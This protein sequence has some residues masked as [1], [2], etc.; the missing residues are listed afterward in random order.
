MVTKEA[1]PKIVGFLYQME[2]ALYRIFSN[3]HNSAVFGIETADD[4]VEE[5][6]F[7]NGHWHVAFEQDK[8]ASDTQPQPYQDSSKNL[9]HTVHIWLDAMKE[10]REKYNKIT[11]CFVT[12]KTVGTNNLATILSEAKTEEQIN[13]A[14]AILKE[15]ANT[16][17]GKVKEIAVQVLR[18]PEEELKFLI[19]NI[20][21]L[22]NHGTISGIPLKQA[23]INLLHIPTELKSQEET[24]YQ[25]LFGFMIDQCLLAWK[26]RQAVE[27]TKGPFSNLRDAEISKIK[28][29][30]FI[31]QPIFDTEYKKFMDNDD[32]DHLF[33]QQLQHININTEQCNKALEHYWAFH[34]E[35]VRLEDTGEVPLSAWR[36]RDYALYERWEQ[37]KDSP[38]IVKTGNNNPIELSQEI[39]TNTLNNYKANLNGIPTD[40]IYFTSGNYHKLANSSEN[41]MF[42]HWHSNFKIHKGE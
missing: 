14:L 10:S 34:A 20:E 4:V 40:Y 22:D 19:K 23:T 1:S 30:N 12:N 25:T 27:L 8:H 31:D 11:Y 21:L 17:G 36:A 41:E 24:I 37:I 26:A 42:I 28:R 13:T 9:W 33:I 6:L 38:S 7:E 18:Y 32:S 35:R 29:R 39:Y 2:R 5:I 15:Q 16:I 3:E